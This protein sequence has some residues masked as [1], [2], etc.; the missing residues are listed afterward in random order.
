ME[1]EF[2]LIVAGGRDFRDGFILS[3]EIMHLAYG[4]LDDRNVS[5]VTGMARGADKLAWEFAR[6]H[7]VKCYEYPANWREHGRRAG[8]LRNEQMGRFADGLLA[9]WDGQSRGTRHM[10][11]FMQETQGKPVWVFR[12]DEPDMGLSA[13]NTEEFAS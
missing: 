9:F 10:I 11:Q 4:P 7:G 1:P 13:Y 3:H 8:I 5:I 6:V 12:Y 2:K